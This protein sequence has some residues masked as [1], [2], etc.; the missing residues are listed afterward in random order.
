MKVTRV[1]GAMRGPGG[2]VRLKVA[3]ASGEAG[4][5]DFTPDAARRTVEAL[6]AGLDVATGATVFDAEAIT[7]VEADNGEVVM[8]VRLGSSWLTLGLQGRVFEALRRDIEA[9]AQSVPPS[10][11]RH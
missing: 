6:L 11:R 8:R 2:H 1:I 3:K 9:L 5:I 7:F 10:S 4:L